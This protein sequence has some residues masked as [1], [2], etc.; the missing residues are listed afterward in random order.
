MIS[1]VRGVSEGLQ[2]RPDAKEGDGPD[3]EQRKWTE[4]YRCEARRQSRYRCVPR[5]VPVLL[6]II[7]YC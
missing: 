1:G 6:E 5:H 4:C 7:F 2:Q 3:E